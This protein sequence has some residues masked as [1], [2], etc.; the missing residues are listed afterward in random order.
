MEHVLS[1]DNVPQRV[2]DLVSSVAQEARRRLG[3]ETRVIWFGS[4]I[5]GAAS[6]AS[7]LDIA[8]D[9]P[10][11]VSMRDY[12]ALWDWVDELPTLYKIDLVNLNEAGDQLR[13]EI[14]ERGIEV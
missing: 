6:P 12:S 2:R 9:V 13:G 11:G 4:W 8:I 10:G 1:I 3:K 14:L 5:R 7:D